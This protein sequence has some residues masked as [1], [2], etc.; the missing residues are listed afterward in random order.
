MGRSNGPS[1]YRY[2]RVLRDA[3]FLN[4]NL[5]HF[6][7]RR[8]DPHTESPCHQDQNPLSYTDSQPDANQHTPT[9]LYADFNRYPLAHPN[10]HLSIGYANPYDDTISYPNRKR[11]RDPHPGTNRHQD[12]YVD[13]NS[14]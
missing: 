14:H 3:I 6:R 5:D 2:G 10:P 1:G 8:S 13:T 9:N 11:H 4:A 12:P 7:H